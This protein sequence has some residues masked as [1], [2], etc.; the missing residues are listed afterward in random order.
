MNE[1]DYYKTT[2][3]A[4]ATALHC[5]GL[6]L[7]AIDKTNPSRAS[8]VFERNK[9]LDELIQAFWSHSLKVDPLTFFNELKQVKTRLY[10]Q[11]D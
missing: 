10:Q 11:I 2:D 9:G 4:L 8:F 3:I 6:K 5:Y 1:N 7:D